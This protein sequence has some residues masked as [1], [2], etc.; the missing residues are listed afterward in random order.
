MGIPLLDLKAQYQSI[1]EDI[2]KKISEVVS[3]QKF[4][5]GAEV[6][7]LERELAAFCQTDFA[8]GVSSGSDALIV[9]LMALEVGDGDE[10]ITT[11]FTFFATAGAIARLKAKPVFC[12][13]EEVSC[14]ISVEKLEELL[15]NQYS[16]PGN[17]KARALIPV[18][19]YGQCAD[20]T[21]IL[22]LAAKYDLLVIED[23]AQAVGA[24]Y[25]IEGGSKRACSM[26]DVGILSFF[27]SKNL[28][29]FG[30]GGMVLTNDEKL[31]SK[32][33]LLRVHGGRDKYFYDILGGNFRLDTLQAAVLRVKLRHLDGWLQKR[34]ERASSYDRLF[35]ESGLVKEGLVKVPRALYKNS[36]IQNF[37]IYHQYVIRAKERDRLQ[38]FLKE[39]GVGTSIYYPLSLHLQ[40]CFSYLGYREGD[41]PVSEKA[42]K[43]VLALPVYPELTS[44][45]QD[46]VVSSISDF[47]KS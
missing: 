29:G 19:L 44:A 3:S 46:F 45:Q 21:P 39:K 47:Y 43:E 4:I 6:E 12:D 32:I 27:P 1:K 16:K 7:S 42:S 28:S 10:V 36:G 31:A 15:E 14:N 35:E 2:D 9:S 33:K 34:K 18:H 11:P 22:S 37:H 41:F 5:L 26:G 23:A 30:D 13:I 40:K 38:E 17:S 24:E 25:P 8:V 20:M